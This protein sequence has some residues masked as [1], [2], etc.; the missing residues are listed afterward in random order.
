MFNKFLIFAFFIFTGL[1]YAC[2]SFETNNSNSSQNINLAIDTTNIPPEFS[3]K[4]IELNGNMPPGIPDPKNSNASNSVKGATPTPGI[5]A[6]PGKPLPKGTTPTPGIPDEQTL[7]K[8]MQ[9]NS[10]PQPRK[11]SN[12]SDVT[13]EKQQND[14]SDNRQD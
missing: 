10:P 3:N 4:Q 14:R 9:E 1:N 6:D 12:S 5:P 7:R 2:N 11:S 8:Q 13:N